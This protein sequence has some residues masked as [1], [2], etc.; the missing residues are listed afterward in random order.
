M[1]RAWRHQAS[2]SFDERGPGAWLAT[3]ARRE[4]LRELARRKR[5]TLVGGDVI[6]RMD[7]RGALVAPPPGPREPAEELGDLAAELGEDERQVLRLRYVEDLEYSVIAA[8]L[9]TTTGAT[10]VRAH[11]ARR[12]LEALLR[13]ATP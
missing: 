6:D 7:D 5:V 8:R 9:G 11:R 4:A 13:A 3:I 1:L 2:A 10:R 12:R